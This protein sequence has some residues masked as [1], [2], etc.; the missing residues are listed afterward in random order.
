MS[1]AQAEMRRASKKHRDVEKSITVA[2]K[3]QLEEDQSLRGTEVALKRHEATL[4][5]SKDMLETIRAKKAE[6][7]REIEEKKQAIE[8][9]LHCFKSRHSLSRDNFL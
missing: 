6:N 3:K 2:A 9:V 5:K 1:S 7:D 8:C 4:K